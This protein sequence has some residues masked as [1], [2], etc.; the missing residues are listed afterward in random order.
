MSDRYCIS[1][2]GDEVEIVAAHGSEDHDH[3]EESNCH[4]HDGVEY[5][6]PH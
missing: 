4:S 1:P 6:S 5:E 2:K 3:E